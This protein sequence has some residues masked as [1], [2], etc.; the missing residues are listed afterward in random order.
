MVNVVHEAVR[1]D[2]ATAATKG[3]RDYQEDSLIASFP[4]G[5]ETGF[6][7]LADGMGGHMCG[8]VASALVMS[9]VFSQIKM[10]EMLLGRRITDISSILHMTATA[11]NDRITEYVKERPDSYGMGATLLAT[12]IRGD[13]LY[14]VS[15]GDSPLFLYRD[16]V[17]TQL[18]QDHSMAPQIDMMVKVGAMSEEVGRNHPDR[19]TLT[20][21]IAGHAIAKIDCPDT[22][23]TVREGDIIIAATDGLQFLSND[24]IAAILKETHTKRSMDISSALL[25]A[26]DELADPDQDNTAFTVIKLGASQHVA[27]SGTDD[28]DG[29]AL[30][31]R[32]DATSRK[33]PVLEAVATNPDPARNAAAV[34]DPIDIPK[35][36]VIRLV[37]S[38]TLDFQQTEAPEVTG[39]PV[40][41]SKPQGNTSWY[42]RR[43]SND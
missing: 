19:N 13:E 31:Q 11:A 8:D 36:R 18:N 34:Q 2:V 14:W 15:V 23:K 29:S 12:V 41:P 1:F 25:A 6:A 16:G 22:P 32:H 9:E 30:F 37:T 4:Q 3:E 38:Q 27:L 26:L 39:A 40:S 43:T 28:M 17:L 10:N 20:S 42:R 21:A 24:T 33:A 7:V 5:Q 35:K